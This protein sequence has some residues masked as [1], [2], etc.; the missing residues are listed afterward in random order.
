MLKTTRLSNEP[1]SSKNNGSRS[2]SHKNDNSRLA[3][4]KND[5]NSEVNRF[6]VSGNSMEHAKK[7]GK[8]S[9]LE[10]LKS[11]KTFKS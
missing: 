8:L 5:G 4:G 2:A 10:K 6:G 9:Q 3:S 1:T 11:V 7:S